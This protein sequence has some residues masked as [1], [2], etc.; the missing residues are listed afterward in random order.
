MT[1]LSRPSS[2]PVFAPWGWKQPDCKGAKAVS[3]FID[4]L[5]RLLGA[6]APAS[7]ADTDSLARAQDEV[8]MLLGNYVRLGANPQVFDG[9][10]V[11][12]KLGM[13]RAGVTHVV[14]I[15]SASLKRHFQ[16]LLSGGR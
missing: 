7:P 8:D 5:Q 15:F 13:D 16:Q 9:Q 1:T 14:P 10:T 11:E 6:C 3:F 4:D 12:L 2:G